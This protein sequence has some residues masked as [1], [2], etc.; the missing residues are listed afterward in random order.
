MSG[1][2]VSSVPEYHSHRFGNGRGQCR[3]CLMVLPTEDG[4]EWMWYWNP[5]V[6]VGVGPKDLVD[7]E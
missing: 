7:L 6:V 2:R 5:F 1:L 4:T 3:H